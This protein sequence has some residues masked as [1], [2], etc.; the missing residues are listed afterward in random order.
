MNKIER[1]RQWR[2]DNPA[3]AR[4]ITRKAYCKRVGINY[5][6]ELSARSCHDGVCSIC[7]ACGEDV[8]WNIDH[9]HVT[10]K[11]RDVIC[12]GCNVF[13]GKLEKR[14]KNNTLGKYFK[15]IAKHEAA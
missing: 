10:G 8:K 2:I 13:L 4:A 6:E 3:R 7:G 15:Y 11:V 14:I 12:V 5:D 1:A 9:C